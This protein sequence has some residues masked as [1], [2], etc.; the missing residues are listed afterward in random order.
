MARAY[1]QN[2]KHEQQKINRELYDR[3]KEILFLLGELFH[4][5]IKSHNEL[6]TYDSIVEDAEDSV[7]NFL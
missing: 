7:K 6:N 2:A 5:Q 3:R 4:R 1:I